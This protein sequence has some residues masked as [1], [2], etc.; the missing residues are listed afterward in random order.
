MKR[1]TKR[2]EYGN[3]DIIGVDSNE[4]QLNLEF[5]ELN[6]VTDA[7][8]RLATYEDTGLSPEQ[9]LE[10]KER[11]VPQEGVGEEGY[12]HLKMRRRIMM[13]KYKEAIQAIKSNYP[14]SNYTMLRDSLDL[15]IEALEKQ[16]ANMVDLSI[17]SS[18][19]LSTHGFM[20]IYPMS[21]R[22]M[23]LSGSNFEESKKHRN[24][25]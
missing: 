25:I 19:I 24:E 17:P 4:L 9:V 5:E 16:I 3:A 22:G 6:K 1:L 13:D 21:V 7:L 20:W 12:L 8:N 10:L 15:A 2:D 18:I 11:I 23:S 14:P